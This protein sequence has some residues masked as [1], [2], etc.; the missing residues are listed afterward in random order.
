MV[1]REDEHGSLAQSTYFTFFGLR[2]I[3]Y[4]LGVH[5]V[6]CLKTRKK[7]FKLAKPERAAT[8]AT[9]KSVVARSSFAW[10]ILV[11]II[12]SRT[13]RHISARKAF[14]SDR[15]E[16]PTAEATRSTDRALRGKFALIYSVPFSTRGFWI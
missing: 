14:S 1:E 11:L 13:L 2:A 16:T 9:G 8:S 10:L 5:S 7:W 12:S 4:P 6:C 15:R 3:R